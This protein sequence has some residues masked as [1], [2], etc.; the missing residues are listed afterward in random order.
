MTYNYAKG[1]VTLV[2]LGSIQESLERF[3]RMEQDVILFALSCTEFVRLVSELGH[4]VSREDVYSGVLRLPSGVRV[5]RED[6]IL[7]D[8]ELVE[9]AS[10]KVFRRD[11]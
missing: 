10:A 11:W 1:E 9:L 6:S 2:W 5:V 8:D 7:Y 3:A 4:L